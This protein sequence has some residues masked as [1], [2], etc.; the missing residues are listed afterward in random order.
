M[1][2]QLPTI[3]NLQMVPMHKTATNK[4]YFSGADEKK[5]TGKPEAE[6]T[7]DT[8]P[9]EIK[10]TPEQEKAIQEKMDKVLTPVFNFLFDPPAKLPLISQQE[11]SYLEERL[12]MEPE[13]V[14][15][16][17]SRLLPAKT[18]FSK[19]G[20]ASN[21]VLLDQSKIDALMERSKY[22]SAVDVPMDEAEANAWVAE[23]TQEKVATERPLLRKIGTRFSPKKRIRFRDGAAR[24]AGEAI[25]NGFLLPVMTLMLYSPVALY[26]EISVRRHDQK[27]YLNGLHLLHQAEKAREQNPNL[28]LVTYSV[29]DDV[30]YDTYDEANGGYQKTGKKSLCITVHTVKRKEDKQ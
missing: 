1:I 23:N 18:Y 28:Q 24:S 13:E 16:A 20:S 25:L 6:K 3:S 2:S 7:G 11:L 29:A 26:K 30:D 19:V 12:N 5:V 21:F 17:A 15:K 14:L 22:D 10:L 8:K 9:A 27:R 4:L